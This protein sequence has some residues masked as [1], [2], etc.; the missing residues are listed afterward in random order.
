MTPTI[1]FQPFESFAQAAYRVQDTADCLQLLRGTS[2]CYCFIVF[3]EKCYQ[4]EK[5]SSG[6]TKSCQLV[7]SSLHITNKLLIAATLP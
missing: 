6:G 4:V 7:T 1:T 3:T 2:S 5:N